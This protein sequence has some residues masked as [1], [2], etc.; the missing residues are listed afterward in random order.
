VG[1][2]AESA[3]RGLLDLRTAVD[4]LRQTNFYISSEILE[5][6]IGGE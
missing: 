6:L 4:R 2:Q 5:R 1:V 3:K